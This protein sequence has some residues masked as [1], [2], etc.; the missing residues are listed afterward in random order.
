MREANSIQSP[1]NQALAAPHLQLRVQEDKSLWEGEGLP[2]GTPIPLSPSQFL[3]CPPTPSSRWLWPGSQGDPGGCP[4]PYC[5][6]SPKCNLCVWPGSPP[7]Y[8]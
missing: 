3:L 6:P 7:Y 1:R 4:D 8:A 5:L 2:P